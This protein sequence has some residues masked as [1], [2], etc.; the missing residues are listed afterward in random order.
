MT[1][2]SKYR[3]V[4]GDSLSRIALWISTVGKPG[5]SRQMHQTPEATSSP[6]NAVEKEGFI[7]L[8]PSCTSGLLRG[9]AAGP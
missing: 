7:A 4:H 6:R 1:S 3:D 2:D 8:W 5:V 9:R